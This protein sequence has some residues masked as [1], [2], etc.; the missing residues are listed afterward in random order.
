MVIKVYSNA[1]FAIY[2]QRNLLS[3]ISIDLKPKLKEHRI[4]SIL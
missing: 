3:N 2:F 4:I 1:L